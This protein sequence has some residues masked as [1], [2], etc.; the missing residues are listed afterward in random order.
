LVGFKAMQRPSVALLPPALRRVATRVGERLA[1]LGARGWLVGGAVRDLALG[2]TVHDLDFASRATPEEVEGAFE[3]VHEVGR[4]F[5]TCVVRVEGIDVQLTTFRRESG[6]RDARRPDEVRFATDPGEDAR[7]RD[8]TC[9]ALYLDPLADELFDP[10]GGL[11]H[12]AARRLVA[13]GDARAR[14]REDGL[15]LLRLVRFSV[16]LALSIDAETRASARAELDALRGVSPERVWGEL[17][18]LSREP[19]LVRGLALAA[20]LGV[21]ERAVPAL[22]ALPAGALADRL[23]RLGRLGG[24]GE[25]GLPAALAC[26]L[27]PAPP[28]PG[29]P[30]APGAGPADALRALRAPERAVAA[31]QAVHEGLAALR[32]LAAGS[33]GPSGQE[34][35]EPREPKDAAL[36]AGRVRLV[37]D[38]AWRDV[39]L[40]AEAAGDALSAA[41]RRELGRLETLAARAR[42]DELFPAPWLSSA[43]LA[44][45]GV[46]RGPLWSRLLRE[47][48]DQRLGGAHPSREEALAWLRRRAAETAS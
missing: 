38:P 16:Q 46:P 6:Y 21:L 8:F 48:E 37:R 28:A 41:E 34:P 5:G 32:A 18:R 20:E 17:E 40:V 31:A 14:F 1:E 39:R 42:P 3:G 30:G 15:R 19:G 36:R 45:A 23:E 9:N 10:C 47:A 7:R 2:R 43:D 22:A 13:V 44:A 12:L 25:P 27:A 11:E 29:V 24:R 33:P 4:V 26:L 35:G